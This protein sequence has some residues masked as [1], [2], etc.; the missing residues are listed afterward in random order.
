MF[1][2]HILVHG[3]HFLLTLDRSILN[4]G[5]AWIFFFYSINVRVFISFFLE[6]P[7]FNTVISGRCI[8]CL[9]SQSTFQKT[10]GIKVFFL[11][12]TTFETTDVVL[13]TFFGLPQ[14]WSFKLEI[15]CVQNK[16]RTLFSLV[17]LSSGYL[18]Q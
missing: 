4:F 17:T 8:L 14:R 1:T 18:P 6:V 16:I 3:S 7:S 2:E 9:H 11:Q 10:L 5:D 15:H 12:E 13:K